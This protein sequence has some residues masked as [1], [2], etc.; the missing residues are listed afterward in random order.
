MASTAP[1]EGDKRG[2]YCIFESD[3]LQTSQ[4]HVLFIHPTRLLVQLTLKQDSGISHSRQLKKLK[5]KGIVSVI[6][7][8]CD[9]SIVVDAMTGL[10]SEGDLHNLYTVP[11][12]K[13]P[14]FPLEEMYAL[15]LY[16]EKLF[17]NNECSFTMLNKNCLS[18]ADIYALLL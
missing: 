8:G 4:L 15:L 1:W 17:K 10:D 12:K 2:L 7:A 11:R 16:L 18:L 9:E 6:T 14:I 5:E 13:Q 3:Y